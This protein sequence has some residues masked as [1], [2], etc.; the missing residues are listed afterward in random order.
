[1]KPYFFWKNLLQAKTI[2]GM[3]NDVFKL[4][5]EIIEITEKPDTQ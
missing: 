4:Y 3:H 2:K 5:T 1:M